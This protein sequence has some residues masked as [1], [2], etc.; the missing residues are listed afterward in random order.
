MAQWQ[1]I[2]LVRR[3]PWVRFPST[4]QAISPPAAELILSPL[5]DDISFLSPL[6]AQPK[7]SFGALITPTPVPIASPS[8]K[9]AA[10]EI[11]TASATPAPAPAYQ[12]R[13]KHYAVALLGD[14]MIDTLGP[15]VPHL[16]RKLQALFPGTTFTMLNYGAGATNIDAGLARIT[17]SYTYLGQ[18]IP[19]L[20]S[21]SPDIVVVE[22][23]GYNP[24]P[25]DQGAL[26]RHWLQLAAIVDVLRNRLPAVKIIIAATIAPNSQLFGDGAAGLSFGPQDK[27][28]RTNVIK[29]YLDST[30]KFAQSQNLPLADAFHPSLMA[31]GDGNV[32]YINGGDRIHYSDP[33]RDLFAQK[34]VE[35]IVSN[36]LLE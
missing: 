31:N 13:Q 1:S 29:E 35:T 5:A 22:S 15:D 33:G 23:F 24:Y 19:S 3:R 4:A 10:P 36:K 32:L 9:P 18:S 12:A 20:V 27:I 21:Q 17:N 2:F 7:V 14:S 28:E 26:E 16:K 11:A 34:V 8:A 30:V 6:V 25:Y